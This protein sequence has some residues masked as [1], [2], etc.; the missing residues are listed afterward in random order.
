ML[1]QRDLLESLANAIV[2]VKICKKYYMIDVYVDGVLIRPRKYTKE[3]TNL[4]SAWYDYLGNEIVDEQEITRV[5]AQAT[6]E[7]EVDEA[8]DDYMMFMESG[9]A[10]NNL[11]IP[12]ANHFV[13]LDWTP[14]GGMETIKMNCLRG[15]EGDSYLIYVKNIGTSPA[16]LYL[17]VL[18]EEEADPTAEGY[19]N[20][21]VHAEY[22]NLQPGSVGAVRST[23]REGSWYYEVI[24]KP[25][26]S[27]QGIVSISS[28]DYL[29]FRY[30]WEADAG[31]DLDTATELLNSG[32]PGVDNNAVGWSCPGNSNSTVTSILKWAGDNRQSGAECVWLSIKELRDKYVDT[33]PNVTE[34][35][36]YATWYASKGTGKAS[37]NLIAYKGGEMSQEG[38]N[39]INTGGEEVYNKIHSFEVNTVKGMPDYKGSYTPVTKITYDKARNQ[40]SMAV[41]DVVIDNQNSMEELYNLFSNYLAK[42]NQ[43]PYTP[44]EDYNPAT[45]KYVDD[46]VTPKAFKEYV[47]EKLG[48]KADKKATEDA[49]ALK[50]D[51]KAVEDALDLKLDADLVGVAGGVAQL[52]DTGKVPSGMLPSYVDDVIDLRGFIKAKADLSTVGI[53]AGDMYYV[54][55]DAKIYTYDGTAYDA[56]QTPEGGKIYQTLDN[57][58][59]WRWSGTAMVTTGSD[60]A[61]GETAQTA[62]AGD[63][64]KKNADNIAALTTKVTAIE[65]QIGDIGTIL[66]NI[67]GEVI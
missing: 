59:I 61:L 63:K 30:L 38:F 52:D 16:V 13:K 18:K 50:A 65:A 47:D 25:E 35:M 57:S 48:L 3:Y 64:G 27:Q 58:K 23:F 49:L 10:H 19:D 2:V 20:I 8:Y 53:A 39:F 51:K 4:T 31:Q 46:S 22:L 29:V 12:T 67:N 24:A 15:I 37:F 11:L 33:I 60:L 5:E 34:F 21:S 42:D 56:G 26:A 45:K 1:Y 55:D 62:Y 36:T 6:Q 7:R 41:G 54:I 44:A 9:V 32:I 40:V 14:A 28:A 43:T 17:P 66:D